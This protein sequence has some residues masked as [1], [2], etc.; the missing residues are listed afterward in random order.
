MRQSGRIERLGT[1]QILPDLVRDPL[2][3]FGRSIG[4]LRPQCRAF[5]GVNAKRG[6]AFRREAKV[7]LAN[8]VEQRARSS[9]DVVSG[10]CRRSRWRLTTSV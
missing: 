4:E 7:V 2:L 5:A 8:A 6:R 9:F 3:S 10:S 1:L